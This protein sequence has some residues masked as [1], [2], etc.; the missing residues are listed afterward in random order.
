MEITSI[1]TDP[2]S[3]QSPSSARD[4]KINRGGFIDRQRS[5][6]RQCCPK[7]RKEKQNDVCVQARKSQTKN[8]LSAYKLASHVGVF[9]GARLSLLWEG[10][11]N[12]Q[13]MRGRLHINSLQSYRYMSELLSENN[14]H[15]F[16]ESKLFQAIVLFSYFY[17]FNL[18]KL[19][20]VEELR[21]ILNAFIFTYQKK[22]LSHRNWLEKI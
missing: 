20:S 19:I 16:A 22:F 18:K 4:K 5:R 15:S 12:E 7:G 21:E 11:K 1:F 3:S 13:R 8:V 2:L 17:Y 9:R 14:R 6:A 10:M